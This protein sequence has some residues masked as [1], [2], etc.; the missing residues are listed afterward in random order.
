MKKLLHGLFGAAIA[1]MVA[2]SAARAQTGAAEIIGAVV[3]LAGA[4]VPHATLTVTNVGFLLHTGLKKLRTLAAGLPQ[5]DLGLH[6]RNS[7]V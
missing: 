1:L 3:D 7:A 2:A 4:P 6:F 5:D